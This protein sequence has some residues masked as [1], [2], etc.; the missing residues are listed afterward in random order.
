MKAI[1]FF[2]LLLVF[3][4]SSCAIYPTVSRF[5]REPVKLGMTKSEVVAKMGTPFRTDTYM[6]GEKHIDVLY[7]QGESSCRSYPIRCHNHAAV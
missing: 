4:V 7:Y 5:A 6:E 1:K 3:A 2:I